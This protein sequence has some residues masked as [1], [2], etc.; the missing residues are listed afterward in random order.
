MIVTRFHNMEKLT[1]D[2]EFLSPAFLG[3]ADQEAELRS[4]PFKNLLRQWWRVA[5][6]QL[7]AEDLRTDEGKLFGTVLGDNSAQ[8]SQ[9]RLVLEKGEPFTISSKMPQIGTVEHPIDR[10]LY[11]GYGPIMTARIDG[12][13]T[14]KIKKFIQSGSVVK[15]T[16]YAPKS[17]KDVLLN[18]I[19][20]LHYFGTIGSRSR[21]GF[22]SVSLLQDKIN[23]DLKPLAKLM[24]TSIPFDD[25]MNHSSKKYP[26]QLC[27]D[28]KG[29]LCW[30]YISDNS[31]DVKNA[32]QEILHNFAEIY[33]KTRTQFEFRARNELEARHLLGYPAGPNHNVNAWD[34]S[35]GRMPSQLRL[36]V[37]HNDQ[38][39]IVGRI[40]HLPHPIPKTWDEK[41]GKQADIWKKVH[42]FLDNELRLKRCGGGAL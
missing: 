23:L 32:W 24:T 7:S 35:R 9:V 6:S 10:R 21:N 31:T 42:A 39:Q 20:L 41:L 38:R 25:R 26:S 4:P 40:L 37:K 12:R 13:M 1:F 5:N 8:A 29:L 16:I 22:G 14:F 34:G 28:N 2:I 18:T 36:M 27:S 30:E 33:M 15:A 19:S 17:A 3:G 11:L